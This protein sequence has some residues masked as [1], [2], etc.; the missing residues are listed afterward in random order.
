MKRKWSHLVPIFIR[1]CHLL[2]NLFNVLIGSFH[3]D[4]HLWSIRRR[5]VVLDLELYAEFSDH[6]FVEVGTIVCDDSLRDTITINQVVLDEPCH[7]ILSNRSKEGSLNPLCKVI[8]G[9]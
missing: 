6:S 5:V 4:I 1:H 3:C 7:H 9:H 2:Y 8:N